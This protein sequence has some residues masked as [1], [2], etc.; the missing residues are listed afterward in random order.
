MVP[1]QSK[2]FHFHAILSKILQNNRLVQPPLEFDL[3]PRN[4][5]ISHCFINSAISRTVP[6]L[7]PLVDNPAAVTYRTIHEATSLMAPPFHGFDWYNSCGT[8]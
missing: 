1:S 5:W 8:K 6:S 7:E 3:L 4:F 2:F